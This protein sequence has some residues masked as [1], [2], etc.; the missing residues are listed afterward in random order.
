MRPVVEIDAVIQFT[1]LSD[2]LWLAIEQLGPFGMDNRSPIFAVRNAK[3]SSPP[4]LW[5]DKHLKVVG[6]KGNPHRHDE[7]LEYGRA[8][9]RDRARWVRWI[10][11]LRSN[12]DGKA[13][14]N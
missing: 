10:L 11:L 7:G 6:E 9:G 4:Q 1:D 2:A 14:G 12:E 8:R 3:L 13:G 5:K